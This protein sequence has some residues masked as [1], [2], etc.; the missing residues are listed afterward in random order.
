MILLIL[1]NWPLV[2][3]SIKLYIMQTY[4]CNEYP[5]IPNYYI[6]KMG[7]TGGK[8]FSVFFFAQ[9]HRLGVLVRTASPRFF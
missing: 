8:Y 6:A 2:N 5:L 1:N 9:K 3:N 4:P 7:F